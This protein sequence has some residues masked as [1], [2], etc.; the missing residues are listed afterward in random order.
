MHRGGQRI[1]LCGM[2][3]Q[4]FQ[5][6]QQ[7]NDHRARVHPLRTDFYQV[8]T[9]HRRAVELFRIDF[10]DNI[11]TIT[12]CLNFAYKKVKPLLRQLIQRKRFMKASF[13][14]ALRFSK[15]DHRDGDGIE[16]EE[17]ITTNMAS[18]NVS[19]TLASN[20]STEATSMLSYIMDTFDDFVSRGSGWVLVD[21]LAL[22]VCVGE[23]SP[24]VGRC[25][26]H[27]AH[28]REGVQ[29]T[30][31]ANEE[32]EDG[33]CFF[34]AIASHFLEG[35]DQPSKLEEFIQ[36]NLRIDIPYPVDLKNITKFEQDNAALDLSI[37]VMFR[38][39]EGSVF[40]LR[41]P[42]YKA[43]N[44]VH[45]IMFFVDSMSKED[46]EPVLHYA[47]IED[48]SSLFSVRKKS[49]NGNWHTTKYHYCFNCFNKFQREYTLEQ[50]VKWCHK[51][52]GQVSVL[53]KEGDITQYE[54]KNKEFKLGYVFFFDFETYQK[55]PIRPCKCEQDEFER[56]PHKSKVIT[57]HEAFA[58]SF[59]MVD[60]QGYIVECEEYVGEDAATVFVELLRY[61]DKKYTKILRSVKD[62]ELTENDR[63]DFAKAT[64]CHI[65]EKPVK[66]GEKVRDHDHITGK[67]VGAA[68]NL[69]NLHR[70]ECK[71]IVGFAHNFSGY[72]SHILV[73]ALA[74]M[75][76]KWDVQA[77]PLN[78][79]KF[80]MIKFQNMV[81]LDSLAFLGA[82]LD[83][84]VETL[85]ASDHTF[86]IMRQ[87]VDQSKLSLLLRKGVYPYEYVTQFSVVNE[88]VLPPQEKF[89]SNLT[90]KGVSDEDYK[91]AKKVWKHFECT[92]IGEYTKLYCQVDTF[93]LAEAILDL[94][95]SVLREFGMDICH[96]LSLPMLAKDIMLKKTK[97]QIEQI[98]DI[99]MVQ[100]LRSNI[101]GGLSYVN[102]RH[103]DV[104]KESEKRGEPV[105]AVYVD[106]NNLYGA[107]MRFAMPLK[108][109]KWMSEE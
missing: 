105:T 61:M 20:V 27:K 23:C 21:C 34:H 55:K 59:L 65:C 3:S 8:Q 63:E 56:C 80:K 100:M 109:Y 7:L 69:C 58:Y 51:N 9:A 54:R 76:G 48:V 50:H 39:E 37:N 98:A 46:C 4:T 94:R 31:L 44:I 45:M 89:F 90:M 101:R 92:D 93:Q 12:R 67:Y 16:G 30:N 43:K 91:H 2:C 86:P 26:L 49:E 29:V 62:M 75:E 1:L 74:S 42:R 107:A 83:K 106:A 96:F 103:F 33:R 66:N 72:D 18:K 88:T 73:K 64:L 81:L 78:T 87:W 19:F 35:E 77:I 47:L 25:S 5:T 52:E 95:E 6:R 102:T 38:D 68:H 97:C 15:T 82:S 84:L 57:E 53:P 11:R 36:K 99:E 70:A 85:V 60:R 14:L 40:P 41:P 108:D 10:P 13:N 17:V 79:E 24:L 104:Q 71:K 22:D 32:I 28:Y